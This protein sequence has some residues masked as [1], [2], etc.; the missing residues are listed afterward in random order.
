MEGVG[1]SSAIESRATPRR[2]I[3]KSNVRV[4]ETSVEFEELCAAAYERWLLK[5]VLNPMRYGTLR[6]VT[7]GSGSGRGPP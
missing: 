7:W 4:Q 6:T 5:G 3:R 1:F 2:S